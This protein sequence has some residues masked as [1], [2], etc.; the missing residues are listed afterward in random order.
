MEGGCIICI[1]QNRCTY[2]PITLRVV[3]K[4]PKYIQKGLVN[5]L[6]LATFDCMECVVIDFCHCD[7]TQPFNRV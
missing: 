4:C 3:L 6:T 2:L 7:T 1:H 5:T